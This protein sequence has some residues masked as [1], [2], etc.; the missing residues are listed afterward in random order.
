MRKLA[1]VLGAMALLAS[2]AAYAKVGI[3]ADFS[4]GL[5]GNY[6]FRGAKMLGAGWAGDLNAR[7]AINS[8]LTADAYVWCYNTLS[9]KWLAERDFDLS[10]SYTPKYWNDLFTVTGGWTYFDLDNRVGSPLRADDSGELYAAVAV[11]RPK[12][13]SPWLSIHYDYDVDRAGVGNQNRGIGLYAQVGIGKSFELKSG[14]TA[15]LSAKAGFDFGRPS[16]VTPANNIDGF[17]DAVI[18][19]GL[20]WQLEKG[21]TFGPAADIW[22]PSNDIDPGAENFRFVPSLVFNYSHSF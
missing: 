15:D 11:N 1:L 16:V 8:R 4:A 7:Y 6:V 17:R 20:T 19:A 22:I 14:W 13:W 10:L 2:T 12:I 3:D 9:R 18:H 21:L 5:T